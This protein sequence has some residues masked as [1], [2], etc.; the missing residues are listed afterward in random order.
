MRD[1][2]GPKHAKPAPFHNSSFII[3]PFLMPALENKHASQAALAAFRFQHFSLPTLDFRL[4]TLDFPQPPHNFRAFFPARA[5]HRATLR[6]G[7]H[8]CTVT[9]RSPGVL[10]GTPPPRSAL[11][12]PRSTLDTRHSTHSLRSE[13]RRVGKEGRS[14]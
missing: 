14:R 11:G 7:R 8:N 3:H 4:W 9:S 10:P 13:E 1:E 2:K 12:Y 6:H 5:H